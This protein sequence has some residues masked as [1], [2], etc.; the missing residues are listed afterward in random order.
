MDVLHGRTSDG[1]EE[2]RVC[3][4]WERKED[5]EDWASSDN[6][7]SAHAWRTTDSQSGGGH[8]AHGH[9]SPHSGGSSHGT[10]A[11]HGEESG[12]IIGNKVSIYRVAASHLPAEASLG[13]A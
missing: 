5:F 8:F 1:E 13:K 2:I 9:G 4:M 11:A 3:T 7:R 6:F 12:P 10:H